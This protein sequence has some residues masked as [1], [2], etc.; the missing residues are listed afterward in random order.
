MAAGGMY[1]L[2]GGGFHRYSVDEVWL[3]PHFEK[4]LY[5]NAL[6]ATAYLHGWALTAEER[7][8]RVV[9]E[10]LDYVLREL[11]LPEGGF[12]SAHDA[13][14]DGEEGLTYTW[15]PDEVEQVL[16]ERHDEWLLPFEGGRFVLRGEIPAEDRVALL[17]AR[18]GRP[19]P[20]RDDKALAAWNGLALSALAEAG[21]RLGRED[22]L[23]AA[24]AVAEFLLGPLSDDGGRLLRSF[25]AGTAKID[26]YLDDYAAVAA[27]LLELYEA[28][29]ELPWLEEARRLALLAVDLF[30]DEQHGGFFLDARDGDALVA[31]RKE[32]DD[33]PVPSG[34]ALLA[35][36][37]LRLAR[38]WGDDEL[39]R[40]AVGVFRL[41]YPVIVR[42]PA[43]VGQL[44]ADLEL[45]FSTPRE[46]AVVGPPDDPATGELRRAVL[47]PWEPNQ[48]VA[49]ST[50][51]GDSAA[52]LVPLLAGKDVVDGRPAVYVCERFACRAPVTSAAELRDDVATG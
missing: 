14:T 51:A 33:N 27:G 29:G 42:A 41:A 45:H 13:D 1:D 22:Y 21:R 30:E 17:A 5:D 49:F 11:R 18:E 10:T 2:V 15:T 20:A 25:R 39:E 8:R 26:A 40:K 4:M 34:N 31:R 12:A 6:L 16:G 46:V 9:E 37:L 48:V 24:R 36:V 7:Y 32:L 43:A 35:G 23:D 28:T 3:V 47:D 19:Q 44:L 38:L 50:G 52:E